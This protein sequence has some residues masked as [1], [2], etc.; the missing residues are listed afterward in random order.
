MRDKTN[1]QQLET[2]PNVESEYHS[3]EIIP[4]KRIG[5]ITQNQEFGS[6]EVPRT[7]VRSIPKKAE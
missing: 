4:T 7:I 1:E 5:L 2:S 6:M 3:D